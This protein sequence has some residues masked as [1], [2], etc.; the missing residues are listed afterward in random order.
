MTEEKNAAQRLQEASAM[1]KVLAAL[2]HDA[3]QYTLLEEP[4]VRKT[5][6]RQELQFQLDSLFVLL[7]RMQGTTPEEKTSGIPT[8]EFQL[9]PENASISKSPEAHG[10]GKGH[11]SS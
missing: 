4:I 2:A 3:E 6:V 7:R 8:E 1:L 11:A 9:C 5:F 10:K